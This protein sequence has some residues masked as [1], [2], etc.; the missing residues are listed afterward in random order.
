MTSG[1]QVPMPPLFV[2]FN[3]LQVFVINQHWGQGFF[4]FLVENLPRIMIML[5]VLRTNTDIKVEICCVR[6]SLLPLA[7]YLIVVQDRDLSRRPGV[8]LYRFN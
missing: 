7:P 5:D 8:G 2:W 1:F 6:V 4:H 3:S